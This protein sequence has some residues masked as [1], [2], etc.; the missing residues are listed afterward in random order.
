MQ[1]VIYLLAALGGLAIVSL[2]LSKYL[3]FRGARLVTCPQTNEP[4]GVEVDASRAALTAVLG[5]PDFHLTACS[6]WPERQGCGQECLKQIEAAPDG[7]LVR[8]ILTK[9]YDGKRCVLCGKG[10]GDIDWL[11][12]KP[13]LM[14][15]GRRT[16]EWREIRAERVP[17][18]LS[19]H[20]PVCW[21]CHIAETFRRQYP[22][23]VVDRPR[24]PEGSP[25]NN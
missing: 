17:E 11:E 23:L 24:K 6:H 19:T 15:T 14:N 3:R 18:V 22:E 12:H 2:L 4:A 8:A 16:F 21:N 10:L 20:L 25:R 13:A 5:K 9:W 1:T 7:C